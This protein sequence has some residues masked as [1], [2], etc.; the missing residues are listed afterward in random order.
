MTPQGKYRFDPW[1]GLLLA[2]VRRCPIGNVTVITPS[3]ETHKIKGTQPGPDAVMHLHSSAG[4]RGLILGGD[5]GLAEAY[6]EGHW[7]T[8]ELATFLEWGARNLDALG[9]TA[10][11]TFLSKTTARLLH[12]MRANTRS[13]ARRNIAAHY[14]LGN[15]FYEQ[16]LDPSMTYSSAVYP[17]MSTSLEVAQQKK[18]ERIGELLSPSPGMEILE[19]G[20]GWGAMAIHLAR[21]FGCKVV[22][23]TLSTEQYNEAS[24][25]AQAE[26]L[27][28]K[29]EFRLQDYRDVP[30]QFDRVVSIEMIEAVGEAN[31]PRYFSV[32]N[33]RLKSG[34]AAALQAITIAD[35]RFDGYR[36]NADFIQKYIFPGGML[37]SPTALR[38][39]IEMAG[40]QMAGEANF[41]EHYARTLAEWRQRFLEKWDNISPLGFDDRFRRMWEYY[42]AYW[43]GGFRADLIDVAQVRIVKP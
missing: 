37:P 39:H 21:N 31:W 32:I 30:G 4:A 38:Q 17:D 2:A 42:L 26:G 5:L 40:M 28:E 18:I 33:E 24:R 1:T 3:G 23:L 10:E 20:A 43:E 9:S 13:G 25:R 19:I 35:E 12:L 16:W 27:G 6:M 22:G 14:D 29:I 7:S 36:Q 15:A 34:G 8:P 11:G 41:G